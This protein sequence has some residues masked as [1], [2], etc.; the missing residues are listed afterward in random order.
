MF[1]HHFYLVVDLFLDNCYFKSRGIGL[2]SDN[3]DTI[4]KLLFFLVIDFK[5]QHICNGTMFG[6]CAISVKL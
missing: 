4:E 1:I 6:H 5:L 3:S 2:D